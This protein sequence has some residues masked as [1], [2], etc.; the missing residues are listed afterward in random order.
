[1]NFNYKNILV[2]GKM[3]SSDWIKFLSEKVF[4]DDLEEVTAYSLLHY[5]EDLEL[6][7]SCGKVKFFWKDLPEG[8]SLDENIEFIQNGLKNMA[9]TKLGFALPFFINFENIELPTIESMIESGKNNQEG[10][11]NF[12]SET[13]SDLSNL[14]IVK[15][16]GKQL[17]PFLEAEKSI[18]ERL[19]GKHTSK[20]DARNL[21]QYIFGK[22]NTKA[23]P[24]KWEQLSRK[25]H[26]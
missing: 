9:S 8:L 10:K 13:T 1:M 24:K 7:V 20:L 2:T 22:I 19:I 5:L 26:R 12:N 3:N 17:K 14:Q 16:V 25:R 4:L 6:L 23:P 18:V 11:I 15:K 21:F